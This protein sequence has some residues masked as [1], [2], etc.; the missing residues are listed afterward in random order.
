MKGPL[1][2]AVA[3]GG[4]LTAGL[5]VLGFLWVLGTLA[6]IFG[7]P[8]AM[9]GLCAL[10]VAGLVFFAIWDGTRPPKPEGRGLYD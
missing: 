8:A 2:F 7:G 5:L 4:T 1:R 3:L 9:L 6:A 10:L